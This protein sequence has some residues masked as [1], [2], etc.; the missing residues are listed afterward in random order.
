MKPEIID[1]GLLSSNE[2][3]HVYR[4]AWMLSRKVGEKWQRI[5][6]I[7]YHFSSGHLRS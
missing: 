6:E 7:R 5:F 4:K 2:R 1:P 3:D